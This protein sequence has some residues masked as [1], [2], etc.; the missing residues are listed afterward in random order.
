MR[1]RS[2]ADWGIMREISIKC[3]FV[4]C[5]ASRILKTN[6]LSSC[7]CGMFWGE[8][9]LEK[10]FP[11]D[12]SS[13]YCE[14]E[15]DWSRHL[16]LTIVGLQILL[17]WMATEKEKLGGGQ[18]GNFLRTGDWSLLFFPR[19]MA[20]P[21]FTPSAYAL[22]HTFAMAT[23]QHTVHN[24]VH[25]ACVAACDCLGAWRSW[26]HNFSMCLAPLPVARDYLCHFPLTLERTCST[27]L[28]I[29]STRLF[30]WEHY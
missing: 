25:T 8:S 9:M 11:P 16:W 20:N 27:H 3:I 7:V 4:L 13:N 19:S 21:S 23:L 2:F 10:M 24:T 22:T 17:C 1:R 26:H 12:K 30:F 6:Q 29:P 15:R 18:N 28:L 14:F 5:F